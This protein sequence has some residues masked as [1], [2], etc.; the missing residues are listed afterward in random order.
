MRADRLLALR[1]ALLCFTSF[2]DEAP[3]SSA[4][5][6]FQLRRNC[7]LSRETDRLNDRDQIYIEILEVALVRIRDLALSGAFEQCAVEA[8]HVHNLPSLVGEANEQRHVYYLQGERSLYLERLDRS[9]TNAKYV[10]VR[11]AP[12][13]TQ[14]ESIGSSKPLS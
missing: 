6:Q 5:C 12:L 11:Y 3:A 10:L 13:W 9:S 8:D 14:L 1:A 7:L 4:Q 2:L